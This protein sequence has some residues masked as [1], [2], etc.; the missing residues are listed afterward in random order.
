MGGVIFFQ[1]VAF[2]PKRLE[3]EGAPEAISADTLRP[4]YEDSFVSPTIPADRVPEYTVEGFLHVST[5]Q[6]VKQWRLQAERAF[7]YQADGIVHARDV[8][9]DIYDAQ[10]R[11]TRVTS[12]EAKY[13]MESRDL[14]LFGDVHTTFPTGFETISPYMLYHTNRRE[15]IVPLAYP[16]EGRSTVDP[17]TG[18]GMGAEKFDFRAKGMRYL[19]LDD[20]IQL[21]SEVIVHVIKEVPGKEPEITTIESDYGNIDRKQ[22]IILFAMQ[23]SRPEDLRFVKIS[24]PGMT[25]RSRRAE[26]RIDANPRKLRTVRA[27]DDVKIEE[28]P[29]ASADYAS[30]PRR[31][32]RLAK[33]RYA[34]AG[35]AEFDSARNL[36]LLR[37]YPQVYQDRDTITGETIIV[38]RDSDLVEVD[39]SNA[40][41][42]GEDPEDESGDL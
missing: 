10:G 7:F 17:K 13:F 19:G 11:V 30:N 23:E 18:R 25:S 36:I 4:V 8:D 14:E 41:S 38:H 31:K 29:Q 20:R 37:D 9:A 26:F 27:L 16:V 24:Q 32:T 33:S 5:Q 40:F 39:Q 6:G 34:T 12:K 2:S 21:L 22:N 28:K 42:E 15:V 3:E 35:V 1:I